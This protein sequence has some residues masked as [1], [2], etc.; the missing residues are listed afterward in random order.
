MAENNNQNQSTS[1]AA[2]ADAISD[3]DVANRKLLAKVVSGNMGG[4]PDGLRVL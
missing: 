4:L 2:A 1:S 3:V